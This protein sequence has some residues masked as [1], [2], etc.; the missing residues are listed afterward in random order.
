VTRS[1]TGDESRDRLRWILG[2]TPIASESYAGVSYR[3]ERTIG[4][5]GFAYAALAARIAPDGSVPVVI[6]MMRPE[7]VAQNG[8]MVTRLFKKEVVALGR[9]NERVPPSPFVVR[10]LDAGA[11]TVAS[12]SR[13][14]ELPWLAIEYVHGGVEGETLAK[15]VR[16]AVEHTGLAFDAERATLVIRQMVAALS[17]IHAAEIIHRDFKPSN[18]LSCG[19]GC[20]E[21]VKVSDFGIARPT[22]MAST[23]GDLT[24]GS[25]GYVAPEQVHLR[26]EIGPATDVFSLGCV[27]FFLLTGEKYFEVKST[28]DGVMAAAGSE[29]RS[30]TRARFLSP[31]IAERGEA[32]RAIDAILAKATHTDPRQRFQSAQEL[33]HALTPWLGA[34]T[35]SGK[36]SQ[37]WVSSVMSARTERT[38]ARDPSTFSWVARHNPGGSS[39]LV[40][41]AWEADGHCLAPTADG[42][43]YWDGSAWTELS[44]PPVSPIHMVRRLGPGRWLLSSDAGRLHVFSADDCF[45]ALAYPEPSR[46]IT[47]FAGDLDDLAVLVASSSSSAPE[48]GARCGRHFLKPL[49]LQGVASI[50]AAVRLDRERFWIVGRRTEGGA[51]SALYF[52]LDWRLVELGA[53]GAPA[54]VTAASQPERGAALAAGGRHVVRVGSEGSTQVELPVP[55]NWSACAVDVLGGEWV[56]GAGRVWFSPG[57]GA[58][59]QE[60]WSDPSWTAPF[61]SVSADAGRVVVV[62]ADGG[63]LEGRGG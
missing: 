32:C 60:V 61:V 27:I 20:D 47:A 3:I 59:F 26:N 23:F 25:P 19:F 1:L 33:S 48:L 34:G 30:L 46:R 13:S 2:Q 62:T 51:F 11:V 53:P 24:L 4:R 18:V 43:R 41:V 58:A 29:R 36:P 14:V 7:V 16:Y 52:P 22:G 8:E 49:A 57:E 39:V 35:S 17:E 42:L 5:G 56:A 55:S 45:E 37:R 15:R 31:E 9:L 63:V 12:D 50:S 6:K 54:L 44:P 10:L 28:L 38:M 21:M 40:D